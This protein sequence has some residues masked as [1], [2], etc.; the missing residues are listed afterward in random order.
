MTV[1]QH[2]GP[3]SCHCYTDFESVNKIVSNIA[4]GTLHL[5]S[6]SN[7]LVNTTPKC[8]RADGILSGNAGSGASTCNTPT[9]HAPMFAIGDPQ[10]VEATFAGGPPMVLP[11]AVQN[12][13]MPN[14][15]YS[16]MM[17]NKLCLP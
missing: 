16:A 12:A 13:S 14:S 8:L 1:A 5:C 3:V 15:P 4:M 7:F 10:N 2:H 11:H 17:C 9:R 6:Q